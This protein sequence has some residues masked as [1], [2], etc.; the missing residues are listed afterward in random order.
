MAPINR[1][2]KLKI[3]EE[4]L[5]QMKNNII[6]GEWL[7]GKKIPGEMELAS[8]FDVSRI[9]VRQAI[10]QLVGMGVLKIKRGEGTFVSD[11]IPTQY[12]NILI[13]YLMI[14]KPSTIDVF[15][16]RC[17][18]E[19]KSAALAAERATSEDIKMLEE[20]YKKLE[21]N[22]DDLDKYIKHDVLFHMIIASA[23]KN[24]VIMKITSILNDIIKSTMR[25]AVEFVGANKG[26][27]YHS[28][29]LQAIKK[30]DSEVAEKF[31][32]KH[33]ESSLEIVKKSIAK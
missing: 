27:Y 8:L 13:P 26:N 19:S 12:F 24:S 29:L 32:E 20:A 6:S 3:S 17:I 21:E 23:T 33:V 15:E 25:E 7:P 31:M 11:K 9:S 30:G 18:L 14:E 2:S 4:V 10:H 5:E 16:Y 22:K 28:K 1:I